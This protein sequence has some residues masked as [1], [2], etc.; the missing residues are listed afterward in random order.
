MQDK[1]NESLYQKQK[2][3]RPKLEDV[4]S[5]YYEVLPVTNPISCEIEVPGSKSITNRALLLASIAKGKSV[6]TNVLFSDDA[7]AFMDC[8]KELGYEIEI[9]EMKKTVE[10]FGG[11]P[12]TKRTINVRSAGTAA[13][14]ITAMLAAYEGDY[15]INAS[16][17]M[18]A[19]PMKPLL[20]VLHSLGAG[21]EYIEKEGHLPFRLY[22]RHLDGGSVLLETG[23]SSQ[24]LSA[25]LMTGGLYK[26]GLTIQP[27][28]KEVARSYIDITLKMIRQ[29]EGYAYKSEEGHYI[30]KPEQK[31]VSQKYKIE[32]D[33]SSACYFFAMAAL[34]GGSILVKDVYYSSMQGDI[35]FLDIL[36]KL[37]CEITETDKGMLVKGS[38]NGR[39]SGI[40]VDMNDCSDQTMTLAALAP[41]ASSPTTIR[42]IQHIR[43]QESDRI[44]AIVTELTKMGIKCTE[45]EDGIMIYPGTPKA[46]VIDTYDDHRMAMAFSLVGLKVNG[47]KIN[48][49]SCTSKTFENYFAILNNLINSNK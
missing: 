19:R 22:G 13:R 3:V 49:P 11:L 21:I 44:Y 24:F 26:N 30:V 32:P 31:Y 9:N 10:I 39:Y 47:I 37:G 14:F 16:E 6:L 46:A 12:K 38:V 8:L 4:V 40:D 5:Q 29:F 27:V 18:K 1:N 41:F 20:D 2:K 7:R 36:S 25:L 23:R 48:N 33:I 34:T 45:T 43:F 15:V 42:N 17:Q 35:K 28:D